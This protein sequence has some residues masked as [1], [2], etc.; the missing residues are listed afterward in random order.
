[1][2]V[3]GEPDL[4]SC[5]DMAK[6]HKIPSHIN[7]ELALLALQDAV[8]AVRFFEETEIT[9]SELQDRLPVLLNDL[10]DATYYLTTLKDTVPTEPPFLNN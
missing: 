9:I 8:S 6:E 2:T 10:S 7:V 4:N 1:M 3:F 5:G